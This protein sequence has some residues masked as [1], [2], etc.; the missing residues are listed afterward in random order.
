MM[1]T[2]DQKEAVGQAILEI[3]EIK[4]PSIPQMER[5]ANDLIA[6]LEDLAQ[7][8]I[9]GF[10]A[11]DPLATFYDRPCLTCDREKDAE[12]LPGCPSA[13]GATFGGPAT[14]DDPE[15]RVAP[16]RANRVHFEHSE[17]DGSWRWRAVRPDGVDMHLSYPYGDPEAMLDNLALIHGIQIQGGFT[18]IVDPTWVWRVNKALAH[19]GIKKVS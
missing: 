1:L 11:V 4:Q 19:R 17:I 9:H 8:G 12:H 3:S 14:Y 5:V 16:P 10:V 2:P 7:P 18:H 6:K 15:I 13:V